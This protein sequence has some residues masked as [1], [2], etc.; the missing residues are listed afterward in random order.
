MWNNRY[1]VVKLERAVT[2]PSTLSNTY[3]AIE[4]AFITLSGAHMIP[5]DTPS[6]AP[7]SKKDSESLN[8][9]GQQIGVFYRDTADDHVIT[10]HSFFLALQDEPQSPVDRNS[11]QSRQAGK[12]IDMV[13]GIVLVRDANYTDTYKRIGLARWIDERWVRDVQFQIIKLL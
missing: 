1:K 5:I 3:G 9:G 2:V 13:M 11:F 12:M 7:G 8:V 6:Q 10:K 4:A